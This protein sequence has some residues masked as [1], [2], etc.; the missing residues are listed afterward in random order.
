MFV[1]LIYNNLF[2]ELSRIKK[3]DAFFFQFFYKVNWNILLPH[4][5]L[6]GTIN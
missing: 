4:I 2:I 3:K 5:D 1:Q 6:E